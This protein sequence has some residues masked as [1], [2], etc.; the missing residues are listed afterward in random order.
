[1]NTNKRNPAVANSTTGISGY[2]AVAYF[3]EGKPTRGNGHHVTV[4]DGVTYLFASEENK[5]TFDANPKKYIPAYGGYCAFGVT[6]EKK[7]VAD[8]EAWKIV[9]GKLYL[10]LDKDVQA[11]W[12]KDV[13]GYIGKADSIWPRIKD[14]PP[15]DL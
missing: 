13:S 11:E 7:F 4:F 2:D 15:S 5:K 10:N 12:G 9:D 6:E 8:P 14:T 3:T 1:M